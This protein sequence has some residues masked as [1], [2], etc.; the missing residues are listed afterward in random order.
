MFVSVKSQGLTSHIPRDSPLDVKVK[1]AKKR[2][3]AKTKH[4]KSDPST[5]GPEAGRTKEGK[6]APGYKGGP[7][8]P[9]IAK[10]AEI[11]KQMY[12]VLTPRIP[13]I[14]AK[15]A[16]M[17]EDGNIYAI[18]EVLDRSLGKPQQTIEAKVEMPEGK[19]RDEIIAGAAQELARQ[20][21]KV[22]PPK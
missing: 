17:A 20:G 9:H 22:T 4:T 18:K 3:A 14:I 7:G 15:L 11:R 13:A 19:T 8:N 6:F 1:T 5:K 10:V 21:W 16:E 12:E 2:C